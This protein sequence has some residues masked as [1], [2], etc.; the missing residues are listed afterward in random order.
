MKRLV[1]GALLAAGIARGISAAPAVPA[2]AAG[3][4]E[5][6]L[7]SGMRSSGQPRGTWREE[8]L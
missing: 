5:G 1:K 3:E 4:R 6:A 2:A 8:D 7:Q